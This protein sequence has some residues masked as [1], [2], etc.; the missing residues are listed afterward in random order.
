VS[1]IIYPWCSQLLTL[2]GGLIVLGLFLKHWDIARCA[3][4]FDILIRDFFGI[5]ITKGSGLLTRLRDWFRCWLSD[6]CYDVALLETSLKEIFGEDRRLFDV[7]RFGVSGQKI[8]VTATTLSD[9]STYLFSNYNGTEKRDKGCGMY[10]YG[11]A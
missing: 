7:D 6:G 3:R 1:S 2:L 5:H 4:I 8:A 10:S 11:R 9:A